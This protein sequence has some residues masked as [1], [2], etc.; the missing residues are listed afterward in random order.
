MSSTRLFMVAYGAGHIAMVL[1]VAR[2]YLRRHPG[3]HVDIMALTTAAKL[4]ESQGFSVLGYRNFTHWFDATELAA[5]AAPYLDETTHPQVDP[6]ETAAYLGINMLELKQRFGD[7]DSRRLMRVQ[8]RWAF[9]PVTFMKRVLEQFQPDAV[10]T[11]NA[12]RTEQAAIDAA[13]VLGIPSVCMVDLFSPTGDPFL[14][15]PAY[16]DAIATISELGKWNLRATGLEPERIHVT[17]NPAFD[18]LLFP[19]HQREALADRHSMNWDGLSVILWPGHLELMPP[20]VAP[21]DDPAAFPRTAEASLRAYVANRKD[22]ALIVRYHPNHA[23]YFKDLVAQDRV[24]WSDAAKRHAHR[25]IHLADIVV[26]QATTIG[27]E[28]AIAGKSVISLDHSPSRFV[29]PC[30]EQGVSRGIDS[31]D[32]LPAMLDDAIAKPFQSSL[33]G[34]GGKAAANV[35]DLVEMTIGAYG[36]GR[37]LQHQSTLPLKAEL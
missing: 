35:V 16:A 27:L 7:E 30:S 8:G 19:E 1:P 9:S 2:E 22:T 4:A 21:L 36:V 12:P 32:D 23:V 6:I 28:A 31:F 25:D 29:F 10:V 24:L 18:S 5:A 3:A 34:S 17:G 33:A 11:T 14:M 37:Q 15:R 20:D 13:A 26:V